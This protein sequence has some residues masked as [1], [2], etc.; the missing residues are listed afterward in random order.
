MT[1]PP[2]STS[3]VLINLFSL[4]ILGFCA[5]IVIIPVVLIFALRSPQN[6][7]DATQFNPNRQAILD[8]TSVTQI[9]PK[10]VGSFALQESTNHEARE[11]IQQDIFAIYKNN[12]HQ[13]VYLNVL[14]TSNLTEYR[15]FLSQGANCGDCAGT[16]KLYTKAPT[17]YG[18]AFCAC[19][20]F[21]QHTL[22]WLNG[23][24]VI[25]VSTASTL[26]SDGETLLNFIKN[27]PF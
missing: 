22:S 15:S 13:T 6:P 17:S 16:A 1:K 26:Q 7:I 19:I 9:I 12:A 14:Q 2:I 20:R 4:A 11:N 8:T 18:Y 3:R 21:A 10:Q 5:L 24:W 27:Y 23:N 25:S